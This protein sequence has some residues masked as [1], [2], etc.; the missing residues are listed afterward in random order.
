MV[1]KCLQQNST[2]CLT[3]SSPPLAHPTQRFGPTVPDIPRGV[4][5]DRGEQSPTPPEIVD[6][7]N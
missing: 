1:K 2:R 5:P 6:Q 3:L 4:N 7:S